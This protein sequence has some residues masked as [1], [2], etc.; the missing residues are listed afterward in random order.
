M[1]SANNALLSAARLVEE[2]NGRLTA[3]VRQARD[4]GMSWSQ[5]A[6]CLGVTRQAAWGRWHEITQ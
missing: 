2:A 6:E 3:A 5:I 4:V 1:L